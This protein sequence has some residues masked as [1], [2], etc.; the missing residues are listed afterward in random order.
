M[1]ISREI[2]NRIDIV[3][4]AWR[5]LQM[6]KTGTNYKALC[7]FHHEK[8]PSF[9]ISPSKNIAYCF[10]CHHGGG[11]VKFLMEVEKIEYGEAV[12]I[13]AKQAGIELKTD[14]Y[15]E[16]GENRGDVYDMYRIATDFYHAELLKPEHT[17]KLAYLHKRGL[18]LETIEKFKIGFSDNS[19]DLFYKL[20]EKGFEEKDILESGIFVSPSRDKFYG[21]IV[22]PIANFTGHVVAF[23]GRVLDNSLPKYLNSP[24][25]RIFDKSSIL[26]GL[27]LAK[28]EIAKSW[29]VVIVEGQMDTV[30]L[31][32]AGFT[33]VVAISGTALTG[34]QIKILKRLT[35]KIYLCLDNDNAGIAATFASIENLRNEDL[36]VRVV[37]LWEA[38]DPDEYLK[39][40]ADFAQAI[41]QAAS[42]VRFYIHQGSK[43]YEIDTVPGK[44]ALVA[45]LMS[46][47][48]AIESRIEVDMY[49]KEISRE[50][51]IDRDTLYEEYRGFK[52]KKK[53]E[54]ENEKKW[55]DFDIYEQIVGFLR[56]YDYFD[57]FFE[58]YGYNL[59]NLPNTLSARALRLL[60]TDQEQFY[61]SD[62]LDFDRLKGVELLLEE[63]NSALTAERI[64]AKFSDLVAI[65]NREL[66]ESERKHLEE[67][68]KSNKGADPALLQQYTEL[69]QKGKRM[70]ILR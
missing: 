60:L 54:V 14:Y 50:L 35:K 25:S 58:K 64:V 43:K 16:R 23:T 48:K 30:S 26:F 45:D 70:K 63:E 4:L 66:F 7:P 17:D 40:W 36:E 27:H 42:L 59:D 32:Q 51:D 1:S 6:K 33:N 28:N 12:Q 13:L 37:E 52:I 61:E 21:R 67:L 22:F 57:L 46:V 24:A 3:E 11:P 9:V 19:R 29:Y 56:V 39:S 10:G 5:Y 53:V 15:K 8:T 38:K 2:D 68:L 34:E 20:R 44:K 49:I 65:L 69:L 55:P 31:H 47:L 18:S 62:L 41:K